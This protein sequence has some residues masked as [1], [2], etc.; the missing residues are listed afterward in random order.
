MPELLTTPPTV[1]PIETIGGPVARPIALRPRSLTLARLAEGEVGGGVPERPV[2][3]F[4]RNKF[5]LL[6]LLAR[7]SKLPAWV[8]EDPAYAKALA[9]EKA[10]YETQRGEYLLVREAWLARGIPCAMLK[11]AGNYPSFPHTS[12]NIDILVRPEQGVAARD[13]LRELGYVELR[14][15]EEPQKFLFRKFHAGRCVS[16]IHVHEQVG[17]LVGFMDEAALWA[18]LRPA[19]DDPLVTIPSP[20]D[21]AL[22][23]LAHACYENKEYRLNDLM[24]VRHALQVTG[25]DL[26]WAYMERVAASRGWPE[27]LAFMLL[28]HAA[29][30]T[31]IFG[32]TLIPPLQRER[33]EHL[34]ADLPFIQHHLDRLRGA[35]A[36]D[37][38]LDLSFWF[39]KRLYYRKILADPART[40]R[41]RRWDAATTLLWGVKLKANLWPQPGMVVTL[42]G[43]DGVGKT[44]HA[45]TLVAVLRTCGWR[46]DYF[47]SRGGSTGL[48]GVI[49][50]LR[51]R[52]QR[53]GDLSGADG[54]VDTVTRRRKAL[55]NP[56]TQVAWSSLVAL[57]SLGTALLRVFLPRLL[58]RIVVT[59]RYA[60]DT[61]VEMEASLPAG[62]RWGR[63]VA[64]ILV[65]LAPRPTCGYVLDA[66]TA[67]VRARKPD[68]VWHADFEDERSRYLEIARRHGLRILSTEGD[69]AASNDVLVREVA[70]AYMRDFET[71]RNALL[72]GNPSQKNPPD[73]V[74]AHGRRRAPFRA[75]LENEYA[76]GG[77]R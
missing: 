30:E 18:R 60:Y 56:A 61:A 4:V 36:T 8:R 1:P 5:P 51:Q 68:E 27:G 53:S 41:Q 42:S 10:W 15:V 66:S 34:L 52:A 73:P 67:T 2:R 29:L 6:S 74:W 23:N 32:D 62:A 49:N 7:V 71:W 77:S 44:A 65:R 21:A 70:M 46:A 50:R 58:G 33:C 11:S 37:L 64:K 13:T 12:D 38:P 75:G 16:A 40:P 59:D 39:C 28:V 22:I 19:E 55:A 47:W 26:D 17:W 31:A 3:W 45:E 20:E 9:D 43:A 54:T 76:R 35:A 69:F 63:L 72:L 57:D 48:L 24:R 14:N 25:G